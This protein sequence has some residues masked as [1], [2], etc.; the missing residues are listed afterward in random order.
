MQA[1]EGVGEGCVGWQ[2]GYVVQGCGGCQCWHGVSRHG[3]E[4][5]RDLQNM[6]ARGLGC[7]ECGVFLWFGSSV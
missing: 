6:A 3:F 5:G 7:A 4:G 1:G 2:V